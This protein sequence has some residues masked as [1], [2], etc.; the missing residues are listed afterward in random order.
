MRGGGA[1][2]RYVTDRAILVAGWLAFLV[3]AFPGFMSFDS[4]WQLAQARHVVP[5]NEWQ[6]P[7]MALIWRWADHVFAGPFPMLVLQSTLFL[8]G[9]NALLRRVMSR[10]AAAIAAVALLLAPPNIVVLAVIWKDSQMAGFLVAGIAGLFST[11]RRWRIAGYACLFLATGMRYNAAAATLPIMLAQF[12]ATGVWKRWHR[13]ALAGVAWFG[14]TALAFACN[15]LL[16]EEHQYVWQAGAAPVDIAGIINYADASNDQVLVETAGVPWHGDT[17]QL[18]ARVHRMYRPAG[19]IY[20][21]TEQ[22]DH[23]LDAPTTDEQRAAISAAWSRLVLAHPLAFV[24]HRF[25]VFNAQLKCAKGVFAELDNDL[26]QH[27]LGHHAVHS[28]LQQTWIDVLKWFDGTIVYRVSLYFFVSILLL[29]L[30][31][32]DRLSFVI[33]ASG[34]CYALGLLAVAPAVDY[35]YSHW[36]VACCLLAGTMLFVLRRRASSRSQPG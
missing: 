1:I 12:G 16:V 2:N 31:R 17:T 23:V 15:A 13:V 28:S 6:P 14:I 30:A 5:V 10:R 9:T 7:M 33:L 35:R 4:A 36:M 32:R 22:P 8:V 20:T 34:T 19:N 18:Q 26:Y 29:P 3:Y 11:D 24:K 21:L 25:A 27:E